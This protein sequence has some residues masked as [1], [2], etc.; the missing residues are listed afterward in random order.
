MKRIL[1]ITYL[2]CIAVGAAAQKD[3]LKSL[4]SN[5]EQLFKKNNTYQLSYTLTVASSLDTT[6]QTMKFD[7]YKSGDKDRMEMGNTQVMIHDGA[8]FIL[9]N[10]EA[11]MIRM[12]NDSSNAASQNIL[13][14][15]F[16]SI[17]DS[18]T[19]VAHSSK[20]GKLN[21]TLLFPSS[22]VYSKVEL[23]FSK[24]TKSLI[25]I[26][27]LFSE[28]YPSEF[29]YLEVNYLEPNFKWSPDANF[30]GTNE[31]VMKSNGRYILQEAFDTYKTY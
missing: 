4:S 23:I 30:P 3:D 10:N 9:V 27:A 26:Y 22:Y 25:R 2:L 12:S 13:V 5:Y 14:S 31:Y 1:V 15:S 19:S 21:Y 7:L 6:V 8:F 16:A 29:K 28:E 24:K 11:H 17:I 18:S 20:D